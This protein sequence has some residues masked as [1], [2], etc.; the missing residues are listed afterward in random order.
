MTTV[1]GVDFSSAAKNHD[2]WFAQGHLEDGTLVMDTV[3]PI[4][5]EDLFGL[6]LGLSTPAVAAMDF[7]FGMPESFL[8]Q[9]G[10]TD[11]YKS[12]EEIW[13]ILAYS[14]WQDLEEIAAEFV[15][16]HN[17]PKRVVEYYYPESKSTLHRT[18]PDLLRM[19][20]KGSDLLHRWWDHTSRP[21]WHLLPLQPPQEPREK[22]VT[23]METMPGAFLRSIGL[24]YRYYK[25]AGQKAVQNREFTLTELGAKSGI[26]LPN[27]TEW[28]YACRAN[29]DCLD[30]VVAATCAAAWWQHAEDFRSPEQ[31]EKAAA[32]REGWLYAPIR[33]GV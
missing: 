13:P 17:E 14:D 29:S 1:V 22:Q 26:A 11:D 10:I 4:R 28:W 2:T 16:E 12:I 32:Q 6:M 25:G 21:P 3:Q 20:H 27:L 19:T 23:V 33:H 18:N 7:P 15:S 30:A 8:L 5:R 24:P 9:I 31:Q